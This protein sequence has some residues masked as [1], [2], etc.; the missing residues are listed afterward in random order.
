V[1]REIPVRILVGRTGRV[2]R[3][4]PLEPG[5]PEV[6]ESA[7]ARSARAMRFV[8]ARRGNEAMEAW[9]SMTFVCDPGS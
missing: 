4:E 8:P 3:I 7:I 1:P 9:F 5:L 6:V 2:L